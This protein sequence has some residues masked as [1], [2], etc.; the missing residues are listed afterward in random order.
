MLL[1]RRH[2]KQLPKHR[3]LSQRRPLLR[4]VGELEA[5]IT[6]TPLVDLDDITYVKILRWPGP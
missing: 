4:E 6:L 2:A 5:T 1:H 3:R